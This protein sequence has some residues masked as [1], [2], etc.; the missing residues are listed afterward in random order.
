MSSA[1]QSPFDDTMRTAA[2]RSHAIRAWLARLA[3]REFTGLLQ[4]QNQVLDA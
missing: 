2:V 3:A 1:A 4:A